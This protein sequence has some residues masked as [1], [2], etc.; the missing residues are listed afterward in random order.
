VA[1]KL[2]MVDLPTSTLGVEKII[3]KKERVHSLTWR[4]ES[5]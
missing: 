3:P 5:D 1:I 4:K 2:K